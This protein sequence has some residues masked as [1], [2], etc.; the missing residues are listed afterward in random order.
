MKETKT[1]K[2]PKIV[3][4]KANSKGYKLSKKEKELYSEIIY[5]PV[6]EYDKI[7]E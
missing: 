1:K 2:E 4:R 3:K 5:I 6:Q 7:Q